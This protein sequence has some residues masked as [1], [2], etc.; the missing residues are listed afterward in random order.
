MN[1]IASTIDNKVAE[2][3][4]EVS[5]SINL[6]S[7]EYV[8]LYKFISKVNPDKICELISGVFKENTL[9]SS[10]IN[11]LFKSLTLDESNEE[12]LGK[13]MAYTLEQRGELSSLMNVINML[14]WII[15]MCINNPDDSYSYLGYLHFNSQ[16]TIYKHKLLFIYKLFYSI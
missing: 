2:I 6:G 3:K 11:K 14:S 15:N 13:M 8:R 1:T 16:Y 4:E 9:T 12:T 5:A 10:D 7:A